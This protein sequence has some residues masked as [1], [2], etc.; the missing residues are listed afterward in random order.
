M[1]VSLIYMFI[2]GSS[3]I[4]SEPSRCPWLNLSDL[5]TCRL[6]LSSKSPA[7]SCLYETQSLRR[8]A[9]TLWSTVTFSANAFTLLN[10]DFW[11]QILDLYRIFHCKV[12]FLNLSLISRSCSKS[13]LALFPLHPSMLCHSWCTSNPFLMSY[14]IKIWAKSSTETK[15]LSFLDKTHRLWCI[16]GI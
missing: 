9:V 8:L 4:T 13:F 16:V 11:P 2:S 15:W 10:L 7:P 3:D 5:H 6:Y 14:I 1:L 12:K